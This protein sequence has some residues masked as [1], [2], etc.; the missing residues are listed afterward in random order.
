MSEF[1]E[2]CRREWRRLG[3]P[4]P[5]ASEMA[6]DLTADLEE[7]EAEGGS[8]E[9]VLGNS[10]FDPRRFAAAWATARGVTGPPPLQRPSFWRQPITIAFIALLG[11]LIMG[12]GL[13]LMVG[14]SSSI[15][16]ATRRIVSDPGSIRLFA[17]G[18]VRVTPAGPLGP[19]VGIGGVVVHPLALMLLVVG[20]AGLVGLGLAILYWSAWSGPRRQYRHGGPRTPNWN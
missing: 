18:P 12:V 16:F 3:V 8:P 19:V 7:A 4:E 5:V 2:E 9:D 13:V 20:M 6:A 1:V 14:R 11:T 10:A 15:A 17:P